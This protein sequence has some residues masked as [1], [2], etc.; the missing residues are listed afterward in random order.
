[1]LVSR[2]VAIAAFVAA[3]VNIAWCDCPKDFLPSSIVQLQ[4]EL[5]TRPVNVVV[6][7]VRLN[8]T[9]ITRDEQQEIEQALVGFCFQ[10][11]RESDLVERIR[12]AFQHHGYFKSEVHNTRVEPLNRNGD[13]PTALV[14]ATVEEGRR[15]QLR[16]IEFTGNKAIPDSRTLRNLIP[17]KDGAVF[18]IQLIRQGLARLRDAYGSMGYINFTPVPDTHVDDQHALIS[19][20][21]DMDEGQQFFIKSISISGV[22]QQREQALRALWPENQRPGDIYNVRLVELFF[23]RAKDLLPPNA[24]PEQDVIVSQNNREHTVE[25]T[26][27][28]DRK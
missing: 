4:D 27:L 9:H 19:L 10:S 17:M 1:V 25:I 18:D 22:N 21:I 23:Q 14:T 6:A 20:T 8:V 3:F 11:N 16:E 26:V 12:D 28:A 24:K 13:P 5:G 2:F 15:Y 7:Q